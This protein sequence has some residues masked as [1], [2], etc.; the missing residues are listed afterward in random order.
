M[1]K[2]VEFMSTSK[3]LNEYL[4]LLLK[5]AGNIY[6]VFFYCNLSKN[7][8]EQIEVV[9]SSFTTPKTS[10]SHDDLLFAFSQSIPDGPH[11]DSF[12]SKFNRQRLLKLAEKSDETKE[13][14]HP[15]YEPNGKIHWVATK[16][17]FLKS[18]SGDFLSVILSRN[19]DDEILR[20]I[21][22]KQ[23]QL[24]LSFLAS[25]Y[26][27]VFLI[28]LDKQTTQPFILTSKAQKSL[29]IKLL[30][31]ISY[32]DII[33]KYTETCI[34][35]EESNLF[36]HF[37][38]PS[39][40]TAQLSTKNRIIKKYRNKEN[41]Y[42]EVKWV[43]IG[44]WKEGEP[45]QAVVGI[46][47]KDKEIRKELKHQKDLQLAK[48]KAEKANEAKSEFLSRMS[49]DIRTP[50]NGVIGMTELAKKNINNPSKISDCL[51]NV[52]TSSYH[53]L[54]L[55]NDILDLNHIEHKKVEIAHKPMNIHSFADGC[56]S[57]ISGQLVNR[58]IKIV[59][60]MEHF[61]Y[62]YVLG[63]ELHLRQAVVN[64]LG[65]ALKFTDDENG[66]IV[67]RIKQIDSGNKTVTYRFQI[68]DNGIGMSK[69][70]L[71]HIW[72][73]FSQENVAAHS[74]HKG[75]GL[76]MPI[77]KS[78]IELMGGSIGVESE[79]GKGSIFTIDISFAID[80]KTVAARR[81]QE[82]TGHQNL[83]GVNILLV[84]DNPINLKS[85][86]ELLETEG[87]I[88]TTAVNGQEAVSIFENSD[89]NSFDAILMDIVMPVMNG[90]EATKEIRSLTRT[91][92]SVIPII[93]I[94]ANA[95]EED[96]RNSM[97]A[98]MNAHLTKPLEMNQVIKTLLSCMRV[99]SVKQAEK[100]KAAL[101]QANRDELTR[102][103][104]RTAFIEKE[105]KIE[106][107]IAEGNLQGFAVCI[108]DVNNLKTTNDTKGHKAG[109]ELI[110]NAS[111]IICTTYQHSPVFR[112]GG[113]EFAVFLYGQDF[114][115]RE[116]L[117]KQFMEKLTP[118]VSIAMGMAVFNPAIDK[119]IGDLT[120]R[121]DAEMYIN[122]KLMKQKH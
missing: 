30:S 41:L 91:D 60:E 22:L 92:A 28:D 90:L 29:G 7:H 64:I 3:E 102:V 67:F 45:R 6:P 68:E 74:D 38:S 13:L 122:K 75:S 71:K 56:L 89:S 112:I 65:N 37:S 5:V 105:C 4:K 106:K 100:L 96:I 42:C 25:E 9:G 33:E 81:A 101:S 69:D 77:A 99:R 53:L 103:G 79:L 83:S 12:I 54:S 116:I 2:K 10:G 117:R 15:Y 44:E 85:E 18:S 51:E 78:L 49:H 111:K 8:Y 104:N 1:S 72:E 57:I 86:K 66:K 11:R 27:N 82:E 118:E 70:F 110:I 17:V 47:E 14:R 73:N 16:A 32:K 48:E 108:C 88:V 80:D 34:P 20:E 97:N 35:P 61:D 121:A 95:F 23:K 36:K 39:N 113:D 46:A 94:T 98:G 63:D 24:I 55:V 21:E 120:K 40:I 76:G 26:S 84:E 119:N 59:L 115:N 114:D 87:A 62:P 19:I 50:I 109:D 31:E 107:E 52:T 58:T 93:A 43:R